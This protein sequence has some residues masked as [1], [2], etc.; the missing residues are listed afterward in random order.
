MNVSEYWAAG[1]EDFQ[2]T[3]SHQLKKVALSEPQAFP[4]W[5]WRS[6]DGAWPCYELIH[7][8]G[9]VR[10]GTRTQEL[11]IALSLLPRRGHWGRKPWEFWA[12][13]GEKSSKNE[14]WLAAKENSRG[15]MTSS[16]AADSV[17][18]M[19]EQEWSS[20]FNWRACFCLAKFYC[21]SYCLF[22]KLQNKLSALL[23]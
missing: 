7:C 3:W 8:C 4:P 22:A 10:E 15:G 21:L 6:G 13:S 11:G 23:S 2:F 18:V 9:V 17:V 5:Q 20:R 12:R 19:K 16:M 14:L 1:R